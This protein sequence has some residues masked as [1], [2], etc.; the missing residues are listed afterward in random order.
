MKDSIGW[1][2]LGKDGV[3]LFLNDEN[4]TTCIA[5]DPQPEHLLGVAN[6]Y[7][8]LKETGKYAHE[9]QDPVFNLNGVALLDA[10]ARSSK[11][12]KAE[13]LNDFNW[14]IG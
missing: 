5:P 1:C 11:S 10:G 14:H 2:Y 9:M 7:I 6:S 12:G 8:Y 4:K 13:L 3:M